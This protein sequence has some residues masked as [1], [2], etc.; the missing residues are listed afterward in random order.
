[1]KWFRLQARPYEWVEFQGIRL[2]P[3]LHTV[4]D[5]AGQ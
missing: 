5:T 3:E 1:M 4:A 2:M